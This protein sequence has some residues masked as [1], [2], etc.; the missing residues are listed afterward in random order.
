M[1]FE[2]KYPKVYPDVTRFEVTDSHGTIVESW[3]RK[4]GVMVNVTKRDA[5][6]A[7]LVEAQEEYERLK[8]KCEV[9][10]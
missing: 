8:A 1:T 4:E 5:A 2:E 9:V 10:V 3:E 6:R 7:S